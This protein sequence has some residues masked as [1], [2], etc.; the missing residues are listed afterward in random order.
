MH[1]LEV[2]IVP[3]KSG[4]LFGKAVI[5]VLIVDLELP[6]TSLSGAFSSE[7]GG[8]RVM[9]GPIHVLR[10]FSLSFLDHLDAL[11]DFLSL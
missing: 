6:S 3:Q 7:G 11:V 9:H 10:P 1:G 8:V 5:D 4:R 2:G